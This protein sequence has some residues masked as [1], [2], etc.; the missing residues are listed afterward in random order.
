[1]FSDLNLEIISFLW[2]YACKKNV[3]LIVTIHTD[4]F[5]KYTQCAKTKGRKGGKN[6]SAIKFVVLYLSNICERLF[7]SK[8]WLSQKVV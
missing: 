8:F 1:M 6:Y 2:K 4:S 5:L 7:S 3:K